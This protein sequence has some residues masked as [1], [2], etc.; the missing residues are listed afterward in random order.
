MYLEPGTLIF[1]HIVSFIF[2]MFFTHIWYKK[3]KGKDVKL[4]RS[5]LTVIIIFFWSASMYK[6]IFLGGQQTSYVLYVLFGLVQGAFFEFNI[7][8]VVEAIKKK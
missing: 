7:K 3:R 4:T 8:D 1:T 5:I 6:E 2:G